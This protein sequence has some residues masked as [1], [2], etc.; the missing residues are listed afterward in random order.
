MFLGRHLV[1]AALQRG[2]TITLFNRGRSGPELFP[3]AEQLRGDR[4]GDLTA[5]AGREWDAVVDTCGYV[6][7]VVRASAT[8]LA[9]RVA[10][11]TFVSSI[12]VYA[13]FSTVG[14]GESY[15]VGRLE[16]PTV[17]VI[18]GDTYGP[19]KVLCEEEVQA[20]LPG[21]A[22]IVRPGLI[23]GPHDP[24]DRFSYWPHR[25]RQGG[26]VLAPEPHDLPVQFIDARDLAAWILDLIE[27]GVAGTF[28]ATGPAV[29]L[30]IGEFLASCRQA[31]GGDARLVWVSRTHL[32][33]HKVAPWSDLPLWLP[34]DDGAH[35]GFSTVDV[36]QAIAAGLAFRP[37]A[38]TLRDTLAWLAARSADHQW[39]A[40]IDRERE[41]AVLAAWRD[42]PDAP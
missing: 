3:T 27:R 29:P 37:L 1:A 38:D 9:A 18:D 20:A 23:V 2:H 34:D 36:S 32:D 35:A 22:L 15:P 24:T 10:H 42:A 26:D 6:P 14:I 21:R 41:A 8:A 28:N 7:R 39:R 19:L 33:R 16:D 17:E 30:T 5:L 25:L 13:D 31:A 12:S 4:D 40:G 11:Y